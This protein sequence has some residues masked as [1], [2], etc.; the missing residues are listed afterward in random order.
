MTR[1]RYESQAEK[2]RPRAVLVTVA[3]G[4][5]PDFDT[6]EELTELAQSDALEVAGI[7]RAR[8]DKPDP[9]TLLGSGKVREIADLARSYGADVVI[10]DATLTAAQERNLVKALETGV[11][12][13]TELILSIFERRARS[14]E[15]RLQVELAKLEHLS[16][17]LV[18]GWTHL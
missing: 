10:F 3:I 11:M 18:R 7:V 14:G 15:G 12:D 9:A 8:R 6:S 4:K 16:T 2:V 1:F 17:R 5:A 13:R